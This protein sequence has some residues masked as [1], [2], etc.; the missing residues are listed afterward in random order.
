MQADC[1]AR[2]GRMHNIRQA[3]KKATTTAAA[4]GCIYLNAA[5]TCIFT[6]GLTYS[7]EEAGSAPSL[8]LL[9]MDLSSDSC[10]RLLAVT[11]CRACGKR[12]EHKKINGE[13]TLT[14]KVNSV[15]KTHKR[16][17]CVKNYKNVM[18]GCRPPFSL[19]GGKR[20]NLQ[21]RRSS[22]QISIMLELFAFHLSCAMGG[23][24]YD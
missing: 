20:E 9:K 21:L 1:N 14:E 4:T 7:G 5:N 17:S 2:A 18:L 6:G 22:F 19:E 15:H 24:E 23:K 11:S 16:G 3:R 13:L 12:Q 10:S 8:I